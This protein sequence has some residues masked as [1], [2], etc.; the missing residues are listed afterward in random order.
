[1]CE[2]E[3][4]HK[5]SPLA[6]ILGSSQ[7][8]ELLLSNPGTNEE[9]KHIVPI[10]KEMQIRESGI[11][12]HDNRGNVFW[13]IWVHL[14]SN[15]YFSL[16]LWHFFAWDIS[17]PYWMLLFQISFSSSNF[18]CVFFLAF[19]MEDSLVEIPFLLCGFPL[20]YIFG[21]YFFL[22]L[23]LGS[24][25]LICFILQCAMWALPTFIFSHI[26]KFSLDACCER[27]GRK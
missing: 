27:E 23:S 13:Q 21:N 17:E 11:C 25:F 3:Q 15:K 26:W 4:R 12:V 18:I 14:Y 20:G 16:W 9:L 2:A 1:M 5:S 22:G 10:R 24:W 7:N 8:G 19:F 6:D